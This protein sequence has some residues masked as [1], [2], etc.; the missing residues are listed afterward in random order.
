MKKWLKIFLSFIG[1]ILVLGIIFFAVDYILDSKEMKKENTIENNIDEKKLLE[2]VPEDYPM[3]QAIK[4][5]CLVIANNTVFNKSKLDSFIANTKADSENRK[6]GFI[7]IVKYTIE[8]D[9]II[10][11]L[12]YREDSGYI[13]TYDNTRDAFGADT[14]KTSYNN[15]PS[16][17]YTIDLI[18]NEHL[19]NV[20]LV[21]QGVIDFDSSIKEYKP[22]IVASFS[23]DAKIYDT[24]PSFIGE[25]TK[26]NDKS[27]IVKTDDKNLGDAV[28]V[29]VKD[30]TQYSIG[31]KV[32]VFY[33][34]TI[35][36]TYPSQIYEIDVRNIEDQ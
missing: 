11:D 26:I 36:D 9:P 31:D 25:V 4:D 34:G 1:I 28:S 22:L 8:G 6:P 3:T 17:I 12:E 13:L 23:K 32:E 21:V 29:S 30:G 33:T 24:A 16:S 35:N 5:G 2:E 7:R 27:I 15:I 14:K 10:T 20:E 18:E 19:I